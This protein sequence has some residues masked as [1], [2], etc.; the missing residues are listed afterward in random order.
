[1]MS[2]T[3]LDIDWLVDHGF[4]SDV[5][6]MLLGENEY[7]DLEAFESLDKY[8]HRLRGMTIR[9]LEFLIDH[10][11]RTDPMEMDGKI[12]SPFPEYFEAW[13]LV[14]CPGISLHQLDRLVA[15]KRL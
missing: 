10:G 12:L 6:K 2:Q 9:H 8:S 13:K 3:A 5:L 14:G 4:A 1:M 11:S 7:A 15:A